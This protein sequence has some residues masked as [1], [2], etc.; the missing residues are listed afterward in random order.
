MQRGRSLEALSAY[1]AYKASPAGSGAAAAGGGVG[2]T[3]T[4]ADAEAQ[5]ATSRALL[6]KRLDAVM[7]AAAAALP[8]ALRAATAAPAA[9]GGVGSDD[10]SG[11]AGLRSV[12][13]GLGSE[14]RRLQGEQGG[15]V[16][17]QRRG[18]E[19]PCF[20][21]PL[22]SASIVGSGQ[23]H[24]GTGATPAAAAAGRRS[25]LAG[26]G[27]RSGGRVGAAARDSSSRLP[28]A[29][30][31]AAAVL[32]KDRA[33]KQPLLFEEEII[34]DAGPKTVKLGGGKDAAAAGKDN[35]ADVVPLLFGTP[36]PAS[37]AGDAGK[38]P[39]IVRGGLFDT[40]AGGGVALW[41]N[42][43]ATGGVG[44]MMSEADFERQVRFATPQAKAAGGGGGAGAG[45]GGGV[46]TYT[47][48][49]SLKRMRRT[50][51]NI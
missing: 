17:L 33:V 23:G 9:G 14:A 13:Q 47:G 48:Q 1:A 45:G 12:L 35:A 28:Q 34:A 27:T 40:P 44:L 43:P 31:A 11:S 15:T 36:A 10:S 5:A 6:H 2:Q 3:A 21:A 4:D 49:R 22:L 30:A 32:E 42:T 38:T 19:P 16:E 51:G 29:A 20:L 41:A 25:L 39:G 24:T 37:A 7:A 50:P 26:A 18:V 46:F 8:P